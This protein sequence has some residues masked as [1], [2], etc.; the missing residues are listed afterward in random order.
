MIGELEFKLVP[1]DIQ[2]QYFSHYT[3]RTPLETDV[4]VLP[5]KIV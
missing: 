3:A 1:Y 2:V 5:I 4:G